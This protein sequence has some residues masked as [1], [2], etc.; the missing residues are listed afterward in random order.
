VSEENGYCPKRV[1]LNSLRQFKDLNEQLRK[2]IRN[3]YDDISLNKIH[4]I[5]WDQLELIT[6]NPSN[7]KHKIHKSI[8]RLN[9][10]NK[11]RIKL[12]K[13]LTTEFSRL[14][15]RY[16]RAAE[17]KNGKSYSVYELLESEK[18]YAQKAAIACIERDVTPR[19]VFEFWNENIKFF[20]TSSEMII[21]S[22][23]F[24]SSPAN[25]DTVACSVLRGNSSNKKKNAKKPHHGNSF[26]DMS[27]LHRDFRKA[28]EEAGFDT[29]EYNDQFLLTI[30][31]NAI[32]LANRKD[33]F[34]PQG[35]MREMAVW[36]SRNLCAK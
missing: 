31:K 7:P 17:R 36:A 33:V 4:V 12:V 30:Q 24:L 32:A 8:L 19:Q 27:G 13:K 11:H 6:F 10:R 25:I 20:K 34:I 1:K 2:S 22:I 5:D 16:R 15:S 9:A 26:A 29:R 21:P 3:K 28:L 23:A 18:K 35:R 14:Y